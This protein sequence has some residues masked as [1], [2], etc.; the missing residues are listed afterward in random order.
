MRQHSGGDPDPV[1]GTYVD[2]PS[3]YNMPDTSGLTYK[4][5]PGDQTHD[6]TLD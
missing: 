4:V 5:Q 1:K 2:I 6:V 3:K